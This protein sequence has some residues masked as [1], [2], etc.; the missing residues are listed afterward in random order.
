MVYMDDF[1]GFTFNG[2]HSSELGILSVTSSN[3][4]GKDLLPQQNEQTISI[5][6]RD[7]SYFFS[8]QF[9]SSSFSLNIAYDK[10]EEWQIRRIR[11]L[12]TIKAIGDL[13]FDEEPFKIY[14]AKVTGKPTLTFVCFDQN[15][16]R[17]YKGEGRINFT[18][19][20]PFAISKNKYLQYYR[21]NMSLYPNVDEWAFAS[22]MKEIQGDY[23]QF[24]SSQIKL[25]NGGDLATD[26]NL[27]FFKNYDIIKLKIRIGQNSFLINFEDA[28]QPTPEQIANGDLIKIT[29]NSDK[30]LITQQIGNGEIVCINNCQGLGQIPRIEKGDSILEIKKMV[31]NSEIN[32]TNELSD[33]S[34]TYNYLY[35]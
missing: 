22:G 13:V 26:Y 18:C 30:K 10:L 29:I 8:S 3:R 19:Y 11:A 4:Y 17:V 2:I 9:Q 16:K 34:I 32:I 1:V 27:T 20:F 24:I 33:V 25:Y 28:P 14:K 35:F 23:D 7:G 21:A 12:F 5:P 31:E 6:G 15:G